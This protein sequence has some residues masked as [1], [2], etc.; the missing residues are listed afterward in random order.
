M[1]AGNGW[2]PGRVCGILLSENALPTYPETAII[3]E[4]SKYRLWL[5]IALPVCKA[6]SCMH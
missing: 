4:G 6:V 3:G 1:S 2:K 5:K